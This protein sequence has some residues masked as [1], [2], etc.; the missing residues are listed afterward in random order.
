MI[1]AKKV[2]VEFQKTEAQGYVGASGSIQVSDA[3]QGVVYLNVDNG[4]SISVELPD[5]M[6]AIALAVAG[7]K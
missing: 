2:R 5:L 7:R 4:P 3:E 1:T 6:T